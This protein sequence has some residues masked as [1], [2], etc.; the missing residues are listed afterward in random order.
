MRKIILVRVEEPICES[1]YE[2]TRVYFVPR[3][4][5]HFVFSVSF[6]PHQNSEGSIYFYLFLLF[7]V[8]LRFPNLSKAT[9][10]ECVKHT[11][12]P[13]HVSP[14][15]SGREPNLSEATSLSH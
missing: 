9:W 4:I 12:K 5:R 11:V 14:P 2:K 6:D 1:S 7:Q 15:D 3:S 13:R 10:L 8:P